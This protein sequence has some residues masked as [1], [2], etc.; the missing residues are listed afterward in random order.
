VT[1]TFVSYRKMIQYEGGLCSFQELYML[2]C[3]LYLCK[4]V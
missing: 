3:D 2:L 1:V 4:K